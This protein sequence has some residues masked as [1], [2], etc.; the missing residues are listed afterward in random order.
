MLIAIDKIGSAVEFVETSGAPYP[1]PEQRIATSPAPHDLVLSRDGRR[2][3][4]TLYGDGKYKA[5]PSPGN[6]I[7]VIDLASQMVVDS[8]SLAPFDSPHGIT[9]DAQGLLWVDAD[10]YSRV[11]A[12]RPETKQ[13]VAEIDTGNDGTHWV[14]ASPVTGMLFCSSKEHPV[15]SVID[16]VERRLIRQI[17]TPHGTEGIAFSPDGTLYAADHKE[18]EI[19]IIDGGRLEVVS[20]VALQ[21]EPPHEQLSSHHMRLAVSSDGRTL[22]AAAYHHDTLML[23]DLHQSERQVAILTG[24]GPMALEFA[25]QDATRLY[26]SN[27]DEGTVSVVDLDAGRIEHTFVCG[28]GIEA[29]RFFNAS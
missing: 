23:V 17:K 29:L 8:I 4:V 28:R 10:P 19:L 20:S 13:I 15:I 9:L 6:Q 2:A 11:L 12:I 5:N 26:L 25:P 27:H 21:I 1:R 14:L 7:L 16:P 18:P 3:Y 22:A 24:A